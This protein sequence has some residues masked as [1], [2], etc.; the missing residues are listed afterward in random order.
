MRKNG[1]FMKSA[2]ASL[3]KTLLSCI[4]VL[5]FARFAANER[6]RQIIFARIMN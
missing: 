2:A 6:S 4:C 3:V 1:T 5:I